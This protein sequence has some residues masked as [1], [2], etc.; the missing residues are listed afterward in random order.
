MKSLAHIIRDIHERKTAIKPETK[1]PKGEWEGHSE[2][3]RA[4]VAKNLAKDTAPPGSK[5]EEAVGIGGSDKPVGT[6]F[7]QVKFHIGPPGNDKAKNKQAVDTAAS[8]ENTKGKISATSEEVATEEVEE[9]DELTGKGEL[10]GIVKHYR[11]ERNATAKEGDF[12]SAEKANKKSSRAMGMISHTAGVKA[13]REIVPSYKGSAAVYKGPKY[14]KME[15]EKEGEVSKGTEERRKVQYV[16][17]LMNVKP[18]DIRSK[19]GRQ[20]SYKKKIIDEEMKK[21]ID[22]IRKVAANSKENAGANEA[23][24]KTKTSSED[25]NKINVKKKVVGNVVWNPDLDHTQDDSTSI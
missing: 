5:V 20:D 14:K 16:G 25:A 8:R 10:P 17:R 11:G 19:V 21:K 12:D 24:I 6:Q 7:N 4:K 13:A 15:E 23:G 22:T 3:E 2:E 9:L 1:T 18:T